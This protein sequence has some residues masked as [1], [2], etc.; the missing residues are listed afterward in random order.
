[1]FLCL[2]WINANV[3]QFLSH[4][5]ADAVCDNTLIANVLTVGALLPYITHQLAVIKKI[6][7]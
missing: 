1:M 7:T 2:V 3:L 5:D 6:I 4:A